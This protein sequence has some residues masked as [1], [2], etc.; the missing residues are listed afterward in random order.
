MRKTQSLEII[1]I[2]NFDI[3]PIKAQ[4][5][6][7]NECSKDGK[8]LK[9]IKKT[10]GT[11]IEYIWLDDDKKE[12]T[13]DEVYFDVVGNFVQEVKK[14]EKV[15]NFEIVDKM[16][17]YDLSESSYSVL[18]CDETTQSIF[19][20]KIEGDKAI[21]FNLK[22]SSRGFSWKKA[23]I[24]KFGNQLVLVSGLGNIKKA[25]SEFKKNNETQKDIDVI[26]QKVE[27]KADELEILI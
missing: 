5:Q 8:P 4:E 9:K 13:K 2:G 14:T 19:E 3:F 21:K 27:M 18:N 1:G 12:Y 20:E 26:V 25:I 24:L 6:K 23:Y 10:D 16:E 11:P 15:K 7:F 17:I 22:K